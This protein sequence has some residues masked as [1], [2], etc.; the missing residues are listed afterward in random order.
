MN[1]S[2]LIVNWNSKDYLRRCLR[3]VGA[4][5]QGSAPQ[6]VVVDGG[7]F[8]GCAEMLATEFPAV[9]FIQSERNLGFGGSNNLGLNVVDRDMLLLLNP[10]TELE[11]GSVTEL[12]Q[13]FS[14]LPD[15]GLLGP[16]LLNSD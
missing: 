16:R 5:C 3:T 10:D 2:I 9:Q 12:L 1:L 13:Q 11:P 15:A 6:I 14:I 8:D 4:A 7:S